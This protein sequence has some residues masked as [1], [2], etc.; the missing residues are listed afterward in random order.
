MSTNESYI[1]TYPPKLGIGPGNPEVA[2]YSQ[3]WDT[4]EY[5]IHAP[6]EFLARYFFQQAK[7]KDGSHVID[8]GCGTGRGARELRKGG[9]KVTLIDFARNCLDPDVREG[10]GEDFRF[11]KHDLENPIPV[12]AQYGYCTDVMEH[13]PT[14]KVAR[15]LDN[16]LRSARTVF[17]A[18]CTKPDDYGKILLGNGTDLHLT[19][20]PFEWW[21]AVLRKMSCTILW[22]EE[23]ASYAF[24]LVTVWE[25]A[26]I[27]VDH[28]DINEE[29]SRITDN[30]RFNSQ[31][32]WQQVIPH[33][34]QETEVM[35]LG[36]GPSLKRHLP[37]I[38]KLRADGV[39][40]VTLNGA[41]NWCLENGLIPSA[42]IIVDA[43]EFNARFTKP[44]V[45]E[46][47]YLLASQCHPSVFEGLPKDRTY[48]WHAR[49]DKWD[50]VIAEYNPKYFPIP[51]GSTALLRA[52][53]LLRMLGFY[54]FHLFGC[55]S[56]LDNGGHH[57]YSQPENDNETVIPIMVTGDPAG[58]VFYCHP[59]MASQGEEFITLIRKLGDE[60]ELIVHGDGLL[61]NILTVGASHILEKEEE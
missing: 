7:P 29:E 1:R 20:R 55:D 24:F 28:G 8:F 2:K 36:G 52:I 31:Q 14:E 6:G 37:E 35:I 39:K 12:V 57:A 30:I 18:I 53:P 59:W 56:C 4:E 25:G 15:V 26:Q 46:C 44:V 40:L 34:Q 13:I 19:V 49:S 10:L 50:D 42:Q 43:R 45:D 32:G 16:I 5:R 9:L 17:F 11:L 54:R 38:Q 61:A 60:F 51:G 58:R 23:I 21:L 3:L 27:L 47:K 41:Y 33:P 22:S 48:L